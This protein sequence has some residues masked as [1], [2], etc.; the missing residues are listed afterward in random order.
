[1]VNNYHH[2]IFISH[3]QHSQLG[4][5]GGWQKLNKTYAPLLGGGGGGR[6]L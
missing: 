1:V 4:F 3:Q 5:R 6:E 2:I